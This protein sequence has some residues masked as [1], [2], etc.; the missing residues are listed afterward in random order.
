MH[1]EIT[2]ARKAREGSEDVNQSRD[3]RNRKKR[4]GFKS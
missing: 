4:N 1:G 3:L 2:Q